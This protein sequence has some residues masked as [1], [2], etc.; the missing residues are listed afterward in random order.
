M[1]CSYNVRVR[2]GGLELYIK[3]NRQWRKFIHSLCTDVQ[4]GKKFM[5]HLSI[6]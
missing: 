5:Y 6:V 1:K 4:N 2:S 3:G